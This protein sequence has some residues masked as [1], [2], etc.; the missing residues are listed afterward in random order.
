MGVISKA[1]QVILTQVKE[2]KTKGHLIKYLFNI[3][4][5]Y[6]LESSLSIT[7]LIASDNRS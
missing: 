4:E 2:K 5:I 6:L 1:D 3:S 7:R